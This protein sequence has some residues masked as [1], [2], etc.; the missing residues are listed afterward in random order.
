MMHG[1]LNVKSPNNTSKWQMGFNS[2]F[3]GLKDFRRV[4]AKNTSIQSIHTYSRTVFEIRGHAIFI[5]IH[6]KNFGV[7][8]GVQIFKNISEHLLY[9]GQKIIRRHN[10]KFRGQC[11]NLLARVTCRGIF[12]S[13]TRVFLNHRQRFSD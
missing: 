9:R 1:P 6:H 13:C 4:S 3:K 5:T 8:A 2:A 12:H 11:A 10:K 7:T